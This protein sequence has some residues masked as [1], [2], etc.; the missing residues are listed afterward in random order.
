[1]KGER[2]DRWP[3]THATLGS[4]CSGMPRGYVATIECGMGRNQSAEVRM[5]EKCKGESVEGVNF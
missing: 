1:M 5:E 3:R 2:L 4:S